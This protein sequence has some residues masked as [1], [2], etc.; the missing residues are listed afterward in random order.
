MLGNLH[1][2]Y[3]IAKS[4]AYSLNNNNKLIKLLY[5]FDG[6]EKFLIY[7]LKQYE[8]KTFPKFTEPSK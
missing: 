5:E 7:D 2:L 6:W 1:S 3:H 4:L 8:E